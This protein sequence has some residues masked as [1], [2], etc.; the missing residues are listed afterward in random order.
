MGLDSHIG[1]AWSHVRERFPEG[2]AEFDELA[3]L[4]GKWGMERQ[5]EGE[6]L[7][8]RSIGALIAGATDKLD[9]HQ[10]QS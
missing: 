10:L 3:N 8:A 2:R 7:M 1:L 4:Y 9:W 6:V 5:E